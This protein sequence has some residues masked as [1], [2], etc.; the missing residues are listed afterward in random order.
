MVGWSRRNREY[1]E[2]Q[3]AAAARKKA[4][5]DAGCKCYCHEPKAQNSGCGTVAMVLLTVGLLLFAIPLVLTYENNK[6]FNSHPHIELVGGEW[7]CTKSHAVFI[8][9]AVSSECDEYTRKRNGKD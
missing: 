5:V 3:A 2:A 9:M 1:A 7:E 8:G 6:K 4:C